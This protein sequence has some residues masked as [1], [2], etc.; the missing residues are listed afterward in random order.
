M[1]Q[2]GS[3]LRPEDVLCDRLST[4][5]RAFGAALRVDISRKSLISTGACVISAL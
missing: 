2:I 1:K 5:F 4:D 3:T